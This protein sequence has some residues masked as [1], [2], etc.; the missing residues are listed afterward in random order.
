MR[1]APCTSVP[2]SKTALTLQYRLCDIK[3]SFIPQSHHQVPN[4]EQTFNLVL[5]LARP[6]KKHSYP[7]PTPGTPC[8]PSTDRLLQCFLTS[9]RPLTLCLTVISSRHSIPLAFKGVFSTDSGTTPPQDFSML[10]LMAIYRLLSQLLLVSH[11]APFWD[12]SSLTST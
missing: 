11:K 10:C 9:K 12:L 5:G 4:Q 3:I 6:P 8:S 1:I 7:L 2:E